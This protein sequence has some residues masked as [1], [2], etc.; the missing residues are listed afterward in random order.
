[1]FSQFQSSLHYPREMRGQENYGLFSTFCDNFFYGSPLSIHR[2]LS[3]TVF[4]IIFG[5]YKD[6]H[7]TATTAYNS[8]QIIGFI[9]QFFSIL[10]IFIFLKLTTL[11]QLNIIWLLLVANNALNVCVYGGIEIMITHGLDKRIYLNKYE[12][13]CF[14]SLTIFCKLDICPSSW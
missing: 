6:K 8:T 12:G 11:E 10:L 14:I 2:Q 3:P 5:T 4:V 9:P 1:M 13:S 7:D